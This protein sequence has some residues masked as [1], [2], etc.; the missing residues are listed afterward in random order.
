MEIKWRDVLK[1]KDLRKKFIVL[2]IILT[3]FA[4][5]FVCFFDCLGEGAGLLVNPFAQIKHYFNGG[6]FPIAF[7]ILAVLIAS[8]LALAITKKAAQALRKDDRNFFYSEKG[9]YGTAKPAT[10]EEI[11][12][13]AAVERVEDAMGTIVGQLSTDGRE[14]IDT[15][16]ESRINKHIMVMGAPGS[17]KSYGFGTTDVIQSVKR[18]DSMIVT[19]PKGELFSRTANFARSHGYIIKRL[20]LKNLS[21]SDGWDIL[22]EV[23]MHDDDL[24]ADFYAGLMADAIIS[25]VFDDKGNIF[26]DG[27][28]MLLKAILLRVGLGD[29][30][31][32]PEKPRTIGTCV[33]LL[34][35]GESALDLLFNKATMSIP[36]QGGKKAM[37]SLPAYQI[38][39]NSSPALR[40]NLLIGLSAAL[41][42]LDIKIVQEVTGTNDIDLS[43]PAREKCIYYCLMPDQHSSMTF[44]SALFFS[45]LFIDLVD[46]CDTQPSKKGQVAVNFLLD[47]F[48]NIGTIPDFDRKIATVR[49]RDLNI[50]II[51]QDI[52][53]LKN[54]YPYTFETLL[55]NCATHICLGINDPDTAK[56]YSAISGEA[57]VKV[58]TEQHDAVEPVLRIGGLRH[59]TGD[60]KR[61][62]YTPDE[63]MRMTPNQLLLKF[64][65]KNAMIANKFGYPEHPW[66]K[67]FVEAPVDTAPSIYNKKARDYFR[68]LEEERIKQFRDWEAAG[69]DES[70]KPKVFLLKDVEQGNVTLEQLRAWYTYQ[71]PAADSFVFRSATG[72]TTNETETSSAVLEV[73]DTP[74]QMEEAAVFEQEQ[75]YDPAL[76]HDAEQPPRPDRRH[77]PK[78]YL[79]QSN[80]QAS[81]TPQAA[82]PQVQQ[83]MG[84]LLQVPGG[85][86]A[87]RD[88][89]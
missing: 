87:K 49:S 32:T 64:Q 41:Q 73:A 14:V 3:L 15:L 81:Q 19:D 38:F 70:K 22:R 60:G 53:Q 69:A 13:L 50:H 83:A 18:G 34:Q 40:G 6:T 11:A 66:S 28:R 1:T 36:G 35:D 59:S 9:V 65:Y 75:H 55:S 80:Y 79:D 43:L 16:P 42:I 44:I 20:D 88:K 67:E 89:T 57:T 37:V 23:Y 78:N 24:G 84:L 72:G 61:P 39:K 5:Y 86:P 12:D 68:A 52:A 85:R 33:K 54:R 30:F 7:C 48:A 58:K 76:E 71:L 10:T 27:P 45:F 25:N 74:P 56:Y 47:E 62:V 46:Y 63:L 31:G 26:E 8:V 77:Q 29:D 21:L 17:G 4:A 51:V 2:S 82:N